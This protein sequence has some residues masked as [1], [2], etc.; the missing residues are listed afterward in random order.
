MQMIALI[1]MCGY[2][3]FVTLLKDTI[4]SNKTLFNLK[5]GLVLGM[6]TLMSSLAFATNDNL[7]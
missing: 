7:E 1:Y 5:S 6:A 2:L 4:M 3:F